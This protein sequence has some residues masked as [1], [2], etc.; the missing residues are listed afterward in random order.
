MYDGWTC[1]GVS[2]NSVGAHCNLYGII[3]DALSD[4]HANGLIHHY[5]FESLNCTCNG[6]II[7]N[8]SYTVI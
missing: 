6:A 3:G 7:N 8:Y 5:S 2:N 1:I 4:K